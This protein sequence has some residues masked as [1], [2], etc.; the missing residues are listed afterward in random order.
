MI[1]RYKTPNLALIYT[2]S[3]FSLA[4][5]ILYIG[6]FIKRKDKNNDINQNIY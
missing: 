3:K 5:L 6:L 1:S 2:N 4:F